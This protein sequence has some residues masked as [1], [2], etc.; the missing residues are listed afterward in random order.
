MARRLQQP[1]SVV[2]LV[3]IKTFTDHTQWLLRAVHLPH[4]SI[5]DRKVRWQHYYHLGR[6]LYVSGCSTQLC[7]HNYRESLSGIR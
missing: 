1:S 5:T 2:I 6:H 4:E 3:L 7:W